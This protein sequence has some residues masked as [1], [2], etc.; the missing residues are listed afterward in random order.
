MKRYLVILL[1]RELS[2]ELDTFRDSGSP[3][4]KTAI[5]KSIANLEELEIALAKE[6]SK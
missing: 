6:W 3:D 1:M 4:F 5:G 2:D